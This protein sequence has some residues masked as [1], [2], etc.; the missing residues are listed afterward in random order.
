MFFKFPQYFIVFSIVRNILN[1][2][3]VKMIDLMLYDLSSPT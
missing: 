1:N 2:Y 3:T